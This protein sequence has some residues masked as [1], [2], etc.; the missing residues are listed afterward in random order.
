MH[1]SWVGAVQLIIGFTLLVIGL[2][3]TLLVCGAQLDPPS[4]ALDCELCC[5]LTITSLSCGTTTG[6]ICAGCCC[7]IVKF[8]RSFAKGKQEKPSNPVGAALYDVS[9]KY[10]N[11]IP[12]G[13]A[14]GQPVGGG[15]ATGVPA[16]HV[17]KPPGDYNGGTPYQYGGGAPA[18]DQGQN[19]SPYGG[20]GSPSPYGNPAPYGNNNAGAPPPGY[21]SAV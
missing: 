1:C 18:Y 16:A 10:G 5:H 4:A 11:Y 15:T 20:G 6:M 7:L 9:A 8:A 2:I 19:S 12:G 21:P 14:L 3:I 17:S 13:T